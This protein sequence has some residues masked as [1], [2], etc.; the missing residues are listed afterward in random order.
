MASCFILSSCASLGGPSLQPEIN[1]LVTSGQVKLAVDKITAQNAD[2][3]TGNEVLYYLDR[4]LI[5]QLNRDFSSSA[6]S[7]E[8]AKARYDELYTHSLTNEA[9]TWVVNDNLAP[10]R[11]PAY[12]RVLMNVFQAFNYLQMDNLSEALVEA[13]DIDSKFPVVSELYAQDKHVFEDNGFA[14]LWCGILYEAAGSREDLNDAFIAYK[15]ALIVYDAYYG[16]TYVPEV[17]QYNLIR[18]AKKFNDP[19]LSGYQSRFPGI[20]LEPEGHAVA[21][22]YL[23]ESVGFSPVKISQMIPVPL[24]DGLITKMAFPQFIHRPYVAHSS[25]LILAGKSGP[26]VTAGAGLAADIEGLADK[27]LSTKKALILA[28]SLARPA[29][30]YLVERNQKEA[31]EKKHGYLAGQLFGLFSDV[32]NFYTEQADV[33]SWQALPAQVHVACVR[34]PAGTYDVRV[35]G[36]DA[37]GSVVSTDEKGEALLK[38]GQTYFFIGRFAR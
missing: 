6:D 11:A 16:G 12:E 35:E 26:A 9:A 36:L 1:G 2:Y 38:A 30:K 21:T 34:V 24:E 31:I 15:Q 3:G 23:L 18:L 19:A 22:V 20:R 32:Y 33:R 5:L 17:L 29:L 7:L 27:D 4:A 10:Y 37:A 28:K 13:R 25:R 8:K 14:R